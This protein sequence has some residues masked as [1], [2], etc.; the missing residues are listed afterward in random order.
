MA[1]NSG[2]PV[3]GSYTIEK[4]VAPEQVASFVIHQKIIV[5]IDSPETKLFSPNIILKIYGQFQN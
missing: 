3:K 1:Y 4:Y 5:N 2:N